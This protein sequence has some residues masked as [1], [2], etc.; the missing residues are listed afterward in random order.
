MDSEP[1]SEIISSISWPFSEFLFIPN[2]YCNNFWKLVPN[3][4]L[5]VSEKDK[6]TY[7]F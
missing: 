1:P 3:L 5:P 6:F 4:D 2:N 7:E